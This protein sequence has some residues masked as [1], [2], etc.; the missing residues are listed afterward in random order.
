MKNLNGQGI[1][2]QE[3]SILSKELVEQGLN[4]GT[5][6]NCSVRHGKSHFLI[7]P[8][9]IS[10]DRITA[11]SIV[12]MNISGA[13][14]GDGMPS[15][16]WRFHRDIY[17]ARSEV[18]AIVHVHSPFATAFSCMGIDLP[19]FHYMIAVAGGK[20]IRCAPYELFGTQ[21]LSDVAIAALVDRKACFLANHGMISVGE[22]IDRALAIAV[23][24][25]SLCE[26]YIYASQL[27]KPNILSEAQ[28]VDVLEKFKG[29]GNWVKENKKENK[30]ENNDN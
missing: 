18:N 9:G 3:L 23:E 6:G 13:V 19:P 12:S 14:E 28:M 4:K 7:T 8:S 20:S 17:V 24:V 29:Y 16:E 26:Q 2:N 27:G 10:V 22:T 25:E 30:K 1:L 15:S 21:E 5:S 11:Q